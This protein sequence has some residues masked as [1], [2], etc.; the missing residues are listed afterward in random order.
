MAMCD[1]RK[2]AEFDYSKLNSDFTALPKP[3]QRAL[4]NN[5]IFTPKALARWTWKDLSNLHGVGPTARPRL[6]EIL[7]EHGLRLRE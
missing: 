2:V 5:S 1:P 7:H 3:L 4:V 6:S